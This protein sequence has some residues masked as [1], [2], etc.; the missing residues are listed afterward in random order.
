[1]ALTNKIVSRFDLTGFGSRLSQMPDGSVI[2]DTKGA[3]RDVIALAAQLLEQ[4]ERVEQQ[5]RAEAKE[6][7]RSLALLDIFESVLQQRPAGALEPNYEDLWFL[8][9]AIRQRAPQQVVEFGSG[10]STYAITLA[11][12]ENNAG[13]LI[14][15]DCDEAWTA[16]TRSSLPS[17]LAT[18]CE[19]M[20]AP[21]EEIEWQGTPAFLHSITPDVQA[22]F[23]YLD[24]PPLTP[25]RRVAVDPLLMEEQ[26]ADDALIVVDGRRENVAFLQRHLAHKYEVE[27]DALYFIAPD[28]ERRVAANYM[29]TFMRVS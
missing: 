2:I 12:R 18:W 29:T 27:A 16:V 28:G 14:S 6:K 22:D 25:E 15:L 26:F 19:I 17:E 9:D 20:C 5:V 21:V 7:F 4:I 3:E 1:M 23:L 13:S 10:F 11:L 24:S 8:F